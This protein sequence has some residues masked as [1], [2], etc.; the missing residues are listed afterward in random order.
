MKSGKSK[1]IPIKKTEEKVSDMNEASLQK[2][3]RK[4]VSDLYF[5]SLK[6]IDDLLNET[7]DGDK[8]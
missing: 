7:I 1:I 8:S 5:D 6:E 3:I 4:R 2:V